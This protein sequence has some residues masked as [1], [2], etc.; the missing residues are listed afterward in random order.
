MIKSKQ[1][2][3]QIHKDQQNDKIQLQT[4]PNPQTPIQN[5]NT[6]TNQSK[7]NHKDTNPR[8][9]K[10]GRVMMVATTALDN[11]MGDLNLNALVKSLLVWESWFAGLVVIEMRD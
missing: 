10:S 5:P 8:W 1:I 11:N 4:N 3:F 6:I 7:S 2:P 9:T